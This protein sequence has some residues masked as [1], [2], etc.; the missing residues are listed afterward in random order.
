MRA[1]KR[2]IRP[3]LNPPRPSSATTSRPPPPPPVLGF[4]TTV[5]LAELAADEPAAFEH[6]NV[7]ASV[8]AAA[9]V[10]VCEPLVASAPLQLPD[11]VQPV[12]SAEDQVIVV[13]P[14]T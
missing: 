7:Y 5:R 13:E 8:A 12:A 2:R 14:P 11:A 9:G 4:A 3:M 10:S 1:R 6:F